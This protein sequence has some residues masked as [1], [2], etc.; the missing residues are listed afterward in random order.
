MGKRITYT[1]ALFAVVLSVA[2]LSRSRLLRTPS[3]NPV[4]HAQSLGLLP[5]PIDYAAFPVAAA[6]INGWVTNNDQSDIRTHAWNLWG[7]ITAVTKLTGDLPVWE[8][9]Y[10]DEE[11][12]AGPLLR[13]SSKTLALRAQGLPSHPFHAPRQFRHAL[14]LK[15]LA[16]LKSVNNLTDTSLVS[17]NKFDNDYAQFVW[18]N[19]YYK[20]ATLWNIQESWPKDTPTVNRIIKPFPAKAIG[21]KPVFQVVNG[22]GNSSPGSQNGI[23]L[24]NYWQGDLATGPTHSTNPAN[25]TPATWTQCVVV[26][27]GNT[28]T[29][30][31]NT[32]PCPNGGHPVGTVTLSSFYSIQLTAD[33]AANICTTQPLETPAPQQSCTVK[34][35]DYAILMAMHMTSRENDNWTWQT[36]WWNYNQPFPYGAPPSTIAAPFNNYAMC[37]GYSMTVNPANSPHGKNVVC[38][39]PYLETG[40]TGVIGVQSD[41]MSCHA[42]ASIGNNP[43]TPGYPIFNWNAST[44]YISPTVAADDT[45]YYNC[46]TTTDFSWFLAGTVAGTPPSNQKPCVAPPP[47]K[48]PPK[49]KK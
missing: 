11:V 3:A 6:T 35:G 12:Q 19:D 36:F 41:C 23:T 27:T 20:S 7:G 5:V 47:L 25:P 37:T 49:Y 42:V 48:V 15:G 38:Y 16:A 17:F 44:S 46:Q 26:N 14:E 18:A 1:A 33:E 43:I 4:V 28:P 39:N 8:T 21:L 29:P 45:V 31:L 9:W 13:G 2:L 22:P 24:L 34:A 32:L 30:P 40:L 10:S